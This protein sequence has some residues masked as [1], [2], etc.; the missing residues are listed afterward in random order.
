M[1]KQYHGIKYPFTLN[2]TEGFFVDL[3]KTPKDKIASE[4]LHVLLTSKG[5]RIR[6]P[7]FGTNLIDYIFNQ[8]DE[9][10]WELV[11]NEAK[12]AVSSFVPNTYLN[13][14]EVYHD[15]NNDNA[16]YLDIRYDVSYSNSKSEYRM[17]VKL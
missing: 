11:E 2:G 4:I 17:V 8:N 1:Q 15:K 16:I 7:E 12:R 10:T 3:N 14:V 5:T 9:M 13:S 6:M